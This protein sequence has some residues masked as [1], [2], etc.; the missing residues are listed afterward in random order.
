MTSLT[1]SLRLLTSVLAMP[2]AMGPAWAQQSAP[3]P[4][5][6]LE[7]NG[8]QPSDKG[9]RLTFVVN[10]T[11]GADLSKAAFEIALFNEAGVVDRLTVLDFKDLPAGKTKVTRFDLA[12]ADCAKVSRVLINSST[13]CAGTGIQPD[14][15]MR[16]LKTETKTGI[17]FGV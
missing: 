1:A 5:L 9:C 8:A 4:A 16:G 13:E 10:N 7:L 3:A 14:A 11:L 12:G 2:L 15:C 17:A 6:T